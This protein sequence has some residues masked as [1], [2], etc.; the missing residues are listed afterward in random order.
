[1][2]TGMK[3]PPTRAFMDGLTITA[4]QII[5][6]KWMLENLEYLMMY[7]RMKCK[8]TKSRNFVLQKEVI[9]TVGE[10]PIMSLGKVF[11]S[12]LLHK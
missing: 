1:M 7:A 4:K 10:K 12:S 9:L 8:S 5:V 6:D 2:A 3:Q 11:E